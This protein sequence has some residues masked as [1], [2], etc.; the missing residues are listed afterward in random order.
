MTTVHN[1]AVRSNTSRY[2]ADRIPSAS[3]DGTGRPCKF[4]GMQRLPR[5]T[6]RVVSGSIHLLILALVLACERSAPVAGKKDTAVA[7]V[8]PPESAVVA[9]PEPTS[10][11]STA[12]PALFVVGPSTTDAFVIGARSGDSTVVD[13]TRF[14]LAPVRAIQIDLFGSGKRLAIARIGAT[15]GS[16]RT[17]SCRTWPSARLQITS[18]DTTSARGWA[19][20]F[21]AGHATA[22]TVDSI[23]ALTTADSAQL[24]A[25]IARIA[26]ALP[27][28]T[29][30]TFRGLPFVVKKAWRA[31]VPGGPDV[32]VA[33]V[34]RNV[35]QEANPRQE[36]ILLIAERDSVPSR[37]RYS[38]RYSERVAGPEETLETTDPITT[39]LLGAD[40]RPTVVV[41][42]DT[43]S[44]LSYVLIERVAGR[45]QRRWA[46]AYA[47]C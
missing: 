34:V 4:R 12:G 20:G 35:N 2:V 42:R 27:G 36:R 7:I 14:D 6:G 23:E 5:C 38:A 21:E 3:I 22:V 10:W 37:T 9:K 17:D 11:D 18:G 19:V 47:G 26:S 41:S 13:S 33:V 43:G 30:V 15:V 1:G 24:A 40:R 16:T 32:L 28:D 44:G 46:S 45:W 8:P 31:L 29:S 39:V 25:D